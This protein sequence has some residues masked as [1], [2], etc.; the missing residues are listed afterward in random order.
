MFWPFF[1][2]FTFWKTAGGKWPID[3]RKSDGGAP[4]NDVP[5]SFDCAMRKEAYRFGTSLLPRLGSFP[6]LFEALD[7]KATCGVAEPAPLAP[8]SAQHPAYRTA[9]DLPVDTVY[10]RAVGTDIPFPLTVND[11]LHADIQRACD[12][13]ATTRS[14]LVVLLP[15]THY[16][17]ETVVLTTRHSALTLMAH[18]DANAYGGVRLSGGVKLQIAGWQKVAGRAGI[19]VADIKGQVKKAP[20]LQINGKRATRARYPNLPGGIEVSPGYGGMISGSAGSWTPPDLS[21]FGNATY[22]TDTTHP[23][24]D[25]TDNWFQHYM[26]GIGGL[27]SVYDPPVSY[28]CSKNPSGGGAAPFRTPSGVAVDPSK[29]PNAPYADVSEAVM[30]VWHPYRWAN[31]MF[32]MAD[33]DAKTANFTFGKGGFQG[34]RGNDLGGDLFIENVFEELDYPGEFFYNR[35]TEQ[36]FYYPNATAQGSDGPPPKDTEFV[37]PKIQVLLRI[38]GDHQYNP[39]RNVSVHGIHFTSSAYT[40]L[41]PHGVPSAGDWALERFAALFAENTTHT[42]VS[43]STFTR[44]DGNGLMISGFNRDFHLLESDFAY[45]GGSAIAS[46][47]YTNETS[48]HNHPQA[49]IDGTDGNHPRYTI[50]EH[51]S[52][53]EVGLYEKQSSFFV[54]AKTAQSTIRGNVFFNGPRAGINFN[55]G[56]GGADTVSRNL[57]F[58]TCRESGDHGPFNSWDRQP[59]LTTVRTGK[60]STRMQWRLIHHNFFIDN[61]S[62]QENVDNDDGSGY[63]LTSD[64]FLVYGGTGL[65]SDFGGHDNVH[66]NNIYAY[67]STLLTDGTTQLK[68]HEDK[69]LTNRGVILSNDV[70]G[71][72]CH[73]PGKTI[74]SHNS[75]YTKNGSISECGMDLADWQALGND[76]SSTVSTWP[77]DEEI[78][79]W[80]HDK[81][82]FMHSTPEEELLMS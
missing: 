76:V 53:R 37:V 79:Q 77:R 82:G 5:P 19:Y 60:P 18:P 81:I 62:P 48:G 30:F 15:G 69:F 45:I 3:P 61:Y 17:G 71:Q 36:L 8:T 28:W 52:V 20:G 73:E 59:F 38:A 75:Y 32:E 74:V 65:K 2:L 64:N 12:K 31:W 67:P 63:F 43:H 78:I 13:A 11:E 49:G 80:W 68:N 24:N 7:L 35:T 51:C 26:I 6:E 47:G 41:E 16:I 54:Q 4:P 55:D 46:W 58:S 57:V 29:L 56:F 27:C 14:K 22:Y 1:S 33:Y 44:L 9:A 42:R 25:T 50:V 39:V 34:A 72:N 23:R 10:V 66:K 21:R 40:Y 70:G